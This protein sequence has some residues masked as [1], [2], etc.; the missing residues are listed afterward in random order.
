MDREAVEEDL[1]I[2]RKEL[3]KVLSLVTAERQ[4]DRKRQG[5]HQGFGREARGCRER[6]RLFGG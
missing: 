2:A 6:N 5:A 4:R 3:D 1:T